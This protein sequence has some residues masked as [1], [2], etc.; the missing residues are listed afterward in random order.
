LHD[1]SGR[2]LV[3]A[4]DVVA[5]V[6]LGAP[7]GILLVWAGLAGASLPMRLARTLVLDATLASA[8][9]IGQLYLPD[10]TASSTDVIAQVIGAGVG[11]LVMHGLISHPGRPIGPRLLGTLRHRPL[12]AVLLAMV[13]AV[14]ADALYPFAVTLDVSTVWD[15]VKAGQWRP[16]GS[17]GRAFW[18]DLVVEKALAYAAI[19]VLAR[20][21]LE[22]RRPPVAGL[23]AWGGAPPRSRR[24][25]SSAS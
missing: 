23:L 11:L 24:A 17:L 7:S 18:P 25:W 2:R 21:V 4:P 8:V 12:L 1:A 3:S 14:A 22:G 15:N 10:R 6:L 9:E 20:A 19:A 13:A 16:L 5:N